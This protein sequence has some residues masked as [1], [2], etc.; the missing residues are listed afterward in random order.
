MK[1]ESKHGTI[2]TMKK[3]KGY[4][5]IKS[6]E[7]EHS[8]DNLFFHATDVLSPV[9]KELKIGDR[10]EYLEKETEKGKSAYGVAVI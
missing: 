6:D 4:G 1:M 10:V 5:F 2:V 3:E 8:K 9:F 7:D